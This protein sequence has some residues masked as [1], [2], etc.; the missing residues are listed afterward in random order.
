MTPDPA[1]NRL[2]E[3]HQKRKRSSLDADE[4]A[5]YDALRDDFARAYVKA[6]RISMRP[7]QT[8]RQVVRVAAAIQ[9]EISSAGR[10]DKTITL[11]LS[12][13]GL[14]A[15][16]GGP[17]EVG[18]TCEFL[19]RMRPEPIRGRGRVVACTRY[20]SGS[21]S[22]RVSIAFDTLT[23]PDVGRLEDLVLETALASLG[24]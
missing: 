12:P 5:R 18:V 3:L 10:V 7:G 9:V 13:L 14:A 23:G 15:L 11:D 1:I 16:V 22:F 17:L 24:R 6:N 4:R 8:P 20:G 2:H 19:L 21:S